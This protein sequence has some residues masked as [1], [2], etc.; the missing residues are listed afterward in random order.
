MAFTPPPASNGNRML[1]RQVLTTGCD[2]C[3]DWLVYSTHSKILDRNPHEEEYQAHKLT[4]QNLKVG[5]GV[6]QGAFAF[7]LTKSPKDPQTVE[8]MVKAVNKVMKQKTA[9]VKSYAWYYEDKG[10]DAYGNPLHPHIHGMYETVTGGR[11][12]TRQWRRAWPLWDKEEGSTKPLGQGFRGGYHR[13]TKFDEAYSTYIKKDAEI[14]G[15]SGHLI[16]KEVVHNEVQVSCSEATAT[17]RSGSS[18]TATSRFDEGT[19]EGGEE[20]Y[21]G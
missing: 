8:D 3:L 19:E 18:E 13:P 2:I 21:S 9:P 12:P 6:Y 15:L 7:T 20:Y 5:N 4:H 11:V 17:E 16:S 14:N 10:L 1:A